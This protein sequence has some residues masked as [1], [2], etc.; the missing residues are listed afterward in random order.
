[1]VTDIFTGRHADRRLRHS[2]GPGG[3]TM[4]VRGRLVAFRRTGRRRQREVWRS[5]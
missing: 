3:A 5:N 2:A 4:D 1:M